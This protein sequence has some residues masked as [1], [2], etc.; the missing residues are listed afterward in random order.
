M[1]E[2]SGGRGENQ[3]APVWVKWQGPIDPGKLKIKVHFERS[4][5]KYFDTPGRGEAGQTMINML[6]C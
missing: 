5:I 4:Q 2:F 6:S 3:E 1:W